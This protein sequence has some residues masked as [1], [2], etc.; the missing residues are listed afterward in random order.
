[1]N[2]IAP[3]SSAESLGVRLRRE[4]ER[5][6]IALSSISA[7]TKISAALFESLDTEQLVSKGL[8]G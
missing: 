8:L 7:N 1:M 4:R 3:S 2:E 5:R 6:H